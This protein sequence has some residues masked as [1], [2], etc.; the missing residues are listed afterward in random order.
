[1][2]NSDKCPECRRPFATKQPLDCRDPKLCYVRL[3][4]R[5]RRAERS[6]AGHTIRGLQKRIRELEADA[7][8]LWA[9][10]VMRRIEVRAGVPLSDEAEMIADTERR[11]AADPSLEPSK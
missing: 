10:R 2:N 1:M 8:A 7:R 5:S 9:F 3:Q 6:C 4:G 11:V